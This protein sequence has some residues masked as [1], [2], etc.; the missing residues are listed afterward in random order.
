M[1]E[2]GGFAQVREEELKRL[3][4][5]AIQQYMDVAMPGF[6]GRDARFKYLFRR[7][8]TTAATIVTNVARELRESDFVPMAFELG[9]GDGGALPA[10]SIRAGDASL[11]VNGKVDR[12]DGWLKDGKL[13]LRVVD[14]KT[15]KKAF[16]LSDLC[17]G[18]GIQMLLYLFALEK[19]G[20]ALFG[21][22]IVPAGVLYLPARDVLVSAPRNEDPGR[23]RE[24]LDKEL[25]RSGMVL[26]QPEVLQA[27][28]HSALESPR[29]LPLTLGKDGSITKGVAT[30][31]ELG[32]LSRYVDKLLERIARELKS[33]N[34]DADPW[35]RGEQDNAC[36]YCE[37]ASACHFMDGDGGDH[38]QMIR[39]V[40]P[41]EFWRHVDQT[42]GEEESL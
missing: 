38:V 36:A 14:Y 37:F 42:I 5:Q 6:D 2:R 20:K 25:R 7:L 30:A 26:S 1:T 18:L 13:Y 40:R 22:D 31:A 3:I 39:P 28:E 10:I 4:D 23:L 9:F 19:E 41:E 32:K 34:I 17:H 35:S 33:G 29:F 16:D 15:G 24:A 21:K 8:R 27:M 12:V 11:T